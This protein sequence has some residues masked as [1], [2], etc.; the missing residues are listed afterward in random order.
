M[1]IIQRDADTYLVRVY[2]GRDALTKKRIEINVTVHGTLTSAR[3]V[4]AKLKAQKEQGR[5]VKT[6]QM[7]LNK[8][9]DAYPE[10][11]RHLQAESTQLKYS[12]SLNCYVRPYIGSMPLAKITAN[13]IQELFNFLLDSKREED[14]SNGNRSV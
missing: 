11:V 1:A 10:S 3:K 12:N 5:L 8:L 2:L 6:P 4:E 9:L 14:E 7:I 13:V